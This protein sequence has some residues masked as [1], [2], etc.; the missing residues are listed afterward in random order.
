MDTDKL[1]AGNLVRFYDWGI[2]EFLFGV[3]IEYENKLYHSKL[4]I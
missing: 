4:N 1:K 3:I 2:G